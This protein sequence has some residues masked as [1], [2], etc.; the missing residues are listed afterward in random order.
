L[1][2]CVRQTLA[3]SS[4]AEPMQKKIA[5]YGMYDGMGAIAL[6][7]IVQQPQYIGLFEIQTGMLRKDFRRLHDM[8]AMLY[9]RTLAEHIC[10]IQQLQRASFGWVI[11]L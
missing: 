5:I 3:A 10:L 1:K 4:K 7:N 6:A 2:V 9:P 8:E 11:L